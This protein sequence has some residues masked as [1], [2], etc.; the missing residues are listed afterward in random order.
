MSTEP[1]RIDLIWQGED[2]EQYERLKKHVI[3]THQNMPAFIKG[4]IENE[5]NKPA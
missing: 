2:I 4:I 3:S 5:L 1:R